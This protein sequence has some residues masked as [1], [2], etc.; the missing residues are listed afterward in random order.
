MA[1]SCLGLRYL[2]E[3]VLSCGPKSAPLLK[4]FHFLLRA[5]LRGQNWFFVTSPEKLWISYWICFRGVGLWG[6]AREARGLKVFN[7]ENFW[8]SPYSARGITF[9]NFLSTFFQLQPILDF[10]VLRSRNHFF[11]LFVNFF[12]T[13]ANF[14]FPRTPLEE[15]LF[16]TFCQLFFN[17]SQFWISP[18]SARGITFF[19]FLSTFFQLQ[20]ILDFPVFRTR[21]IIGTDG[22]KFFFQL[23][24]I[25]VFPVFRTR[26]II[27]TDGGNFFLIFE[28]S[29]F[30]RAPG[31][32][33]VFNLG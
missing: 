6:F 17:F 22:G 24:K 12:P 19:N 26:K 30:S 27:G 16:S 4:N 3:L 5:V 13:S 8:I 15:S 33:S 1:F 7:F 18:Y 25:L 29:G 28:N 2:P 23:L 20:P 21:K 14:G 32:E 31:G 11:Q 9:F 10:P